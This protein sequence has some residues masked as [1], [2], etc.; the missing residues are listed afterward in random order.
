MLTVAGYLSEGSLEDWSLIPPSASCVN[1]VHVR[2]YFLQ[3]APE[4]LAQLTGVSGI[5]H[6]RE[7]FH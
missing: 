4:G 6:F 2:F 3:M 7:G 1:L 5:R